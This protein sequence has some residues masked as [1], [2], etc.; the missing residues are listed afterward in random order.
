MQQK[1]E[2]MQLFLSP[3]GMGRNALIENRFDWRPLSAQNAAK[4]K[5]LNE[6]VL[7]NQVADAGVFNGR[8]LS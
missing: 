1:S 2:E 6:W 5:I 4:I 8:S 3:I 7:Q